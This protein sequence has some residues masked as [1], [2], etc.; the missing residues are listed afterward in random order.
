MNS[1]ARTDAILTTTRL[2]IR[3][4]RRSDQATL[5]SELNTPEVTE[6]LGGIVSQKGLFQWLLEDQQKEYGHTFWP[7]EHKESGEFL[8]ICG[9]VTVDEQDSTVLGAIEIGYRLKVGAQGNRYATEAAAACL[10]YAFE[11]EQVWRVVS[12]TIIENTGSW[13]VMKRI[14]MRHDPRLDYVSSDGTPF[15]VHVMTLRDW[16]REGREICRSLISDPLPPAPEK[17]SGVR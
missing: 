7:I 1:G 9:L 2:C 14:G 3:R 6:H 11:E 13:G 8:G 5:E 16:E 12:R 10:E 4:L 17:S 15:I